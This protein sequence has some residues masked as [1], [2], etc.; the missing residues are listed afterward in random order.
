MPSIALYLKTHQPFRI[1]HY[2][3]FDVGH[4]HEYFNDKGEGNTNNIK[5]LKKVCEKSCPISETFGIKQ[6]RLGH[7]TKPFFKSLIKIN[8]ADYD[9][10][11]APHPSCLRTAQDAESDGIILTVRFVRNSTTPCFNAKR[12]KSFPC[13]TWRPGRKLD[14]R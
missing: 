13:P 12:V 1:K 11:L 5:I 6:K 2:R 14:P 4:D 8:H 7:L 9:S 3:A 10:G